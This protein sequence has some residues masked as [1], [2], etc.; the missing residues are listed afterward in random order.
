MHQKP[1][2]FYS[3]HFVKEELTFLS[4][5]LI[6]LYRQY[7]GTGLGLWISKNIIELM[8]GKISVTSTLKMGSTFHVKIP[9]NVCPE[10]A[11][12]QELTETQNIFPIIKS[13]IYRR[14]KNR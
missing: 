6:L 9:A 1:L 12:I 10:N 8:G 3:N 13:N 4:I 11:I 14:R 7:G 5:W 2:K